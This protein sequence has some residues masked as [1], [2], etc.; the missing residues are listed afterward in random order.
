MFG[1]HLRP[2]NKYLLC[3]TAFLTMKMGAQIE[4]KEYC[5]MSG[6]KIHNICYMIGFQLNAQ[7]TTKEL[8]KNDYD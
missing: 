6:T 8:M 1:V 2:S 5:N 3:T 4:A 7:Y